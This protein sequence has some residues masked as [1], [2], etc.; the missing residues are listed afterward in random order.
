MDQ[1]PKL[2]GGAIALFVLVAIFQVLAL[3]LLMGW[4]L[5]TQAERVGSIL[6]GWV[7]ALGVVWWFWRR[8]VGR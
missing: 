3:V 2:I 8:G 5:G 4:G 7:C 1:F 6:L